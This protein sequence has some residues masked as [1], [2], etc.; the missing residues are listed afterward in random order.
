[1]LKRWL[2]VLGFDVD[3]I[4][5]LTDIDDKIIKRVARDGVTLAE[6]TNKFADFF[7]EVG[8]WPVYRLLALANSP[9]PAPPA[10]PATPATPATPAPKTPHPT[11]TPK[12]P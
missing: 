7:F 11:T 6:L 5:N 9:P 4:C 10:S 1:M 3:H 8:V 2:T 12:H